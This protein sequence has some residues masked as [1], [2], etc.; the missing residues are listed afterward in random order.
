MSKALNEHYAALEEILAKKYNTHLA[1]VIVR[2]LMV[3][4]QDQELPQRLSPMLMK[5]GPEAFSAWGAD[6]T[7]N[8]GVYLGRYYKQ[9]KSC[10][11]MLLACL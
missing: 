11:D 2:L 1:L 4:H 7:R 8:A 3:F 5:I 9:D 10:K 6:F